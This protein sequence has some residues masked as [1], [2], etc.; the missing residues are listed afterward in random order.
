MRPTPSSP[1]PCARPT[2][3]CCTT[4]R[5]ASTW[6]GP[7][8]SPGHDGVARRAARPAGVGRRADRRRAPQGVRPRRA[9]G[10]PA[11]VDD[12]LAP[13]AGDG[14]GVRHRPGRAAS[15][16]RPAGRPT[17]SPCASFGDASLNHSTAQGALNAAAYT[18]HQ[19]MPMPLLLVCEDNGLGH[20]RADARPGGSRRRCAGRPGLRYERADE[21]RPGR[22]VRRRRGARRA[23]ARESA[24][25]PCCTCAPCASAAT[26]APTSSR[27]TARRPAM[28]AEQARDPLLAT[29]RRARRRRRGDAGRR[30][31]PATSTAGRRCGRGPTS[32]AERPPLRTRGR[33]RR[34][35]GA[36]PAGGRRRSRR[37][38]RRRRRA[39]A[40]SSAACPRTRGR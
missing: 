30:S 38:R 13:A 7:S 39:A 11:D 31:S 10:H 37:R 28:R 9:G 32:C 25:R 22:R 29:A 35:A 6:P 21:H 12:R 5:A 20:Q 4:A 15:A 34:P 16:C 33:G 14:R 3:R 23:R 24:A 36:A 26:P 19:G 2:R 1:P 18:A 40:R 27:P 17:P 8:R